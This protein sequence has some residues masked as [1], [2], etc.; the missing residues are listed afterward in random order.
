MFSLALWPV[1]LLEDTAAL[2]RMH[3]LQIFI[4]ISLSALS[5]T[6]CF[7]PP[8]NLHLSWREDNK[9]CRNRSVVRHNE[10]HPRSRCMF[11]N[12]FYTIQRT[13]SMVFIPV[14][15]SQCSIS[16]GWMKMM[17]T[18]WSS[19][20][21]IVFK[22]QFFFFYSSVHGICSCS[23]APPP[24]VKSKHSFSLIANGK[25]RKEMT[26]YRQNMWWKPCNRSQQPMDK[27]WEQI[28]L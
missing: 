11:E 8:M 1:V 19:L 18:K 23:A 14:W 10:E 21:V 25:L 24:P 22:F 26:E 4:K 15:T 2:E 12:T 16:H 9:N 7:L 20:S 6:S 27:I 28:M 3:F 17:L 13:I 5:R